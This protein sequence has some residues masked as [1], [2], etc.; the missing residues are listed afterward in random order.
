MTERSLATL[1]LVPRHRPRACDQ[2][3]R[4]SWDFV[5]DGQSLGELLA[6]EAA[7]VFGAGLVPDAAAHVER[8]LARV[9]GDVA[10]N[11]VRLY[12]CPECGGFDCGAVTTAVERVGD[13]LVWRD[14]GWESDDGAPAR[15]APAGP[16]VF[17]RASY[18]RALRAALATVPGPGVAPIRAV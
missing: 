12:V 15:V 11:R 7:G 16:F 13:T 17:A 18:G 3:E 14:L 4:W 9:P 6:G 8:L 5:V 1:T 10:P 2:T